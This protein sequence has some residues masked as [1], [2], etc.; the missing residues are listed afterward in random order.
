MIDGL[1]GATEHFIEQRI[2]ALLVSEEN[3]LRIDLI[4][5][6]TE[7]KLYEATKVLNEEERFSLIEDIRSN[8]FEQ[9]FFQTKQAYRQGFIDS[10]TFM[11]DHPI[12]K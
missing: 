11:I 5:R 7:E 2:E 12:K 8:I 10:M 6:D 1:K 9:V 4:Y 3:Q